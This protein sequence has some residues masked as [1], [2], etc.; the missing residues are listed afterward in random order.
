MAVDKNA[1]YLHIFVDFLSGIVDCT[2]MFTPF[3]RT[4][5]IDYTAETAYGSFVRITVFVVL[6]AVT[7]GSTGFWV[8]KR[9]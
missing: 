2:W 9:R 8:V 7:M 1:L 5:D 4:L 6:I 3:W